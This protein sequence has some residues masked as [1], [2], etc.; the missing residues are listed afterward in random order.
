MKKYLFLALT[1]ALGASVFTSCTNDA[2]V[3]LGKTID[4]AQKEYASAFKE[5]FGDCDMMAVKYVNVE[6]YIPE[7]TG[8]FTL[9][10]YDGHPA[11]AQ[12]IGKF[13]NLTPA[14]TVNVGVNCP[15]D[16][17]RLFFTLEQNGASKV[18]NCS[19]TKSNKA[20]ARFAP[21]RDESYQNYIDGTF[22]LDP[23]VNG[24]AW[25]SRDFYNGI[26]KA[27]VTIAGLTDEGVDHRTAAADA[28]FAFNEDGEVTFYPVHMNGICPNQIGY[29]IYDMDRIKEGKGAII[30]EGIFINDMSQ[31]SSEKFLMKGSTDQ[32]PETFYNPFGDNVIE[33]TT[34]NYVYSRPFTVKVPDAYNN[35]FTNLVVGLTIYN[36]WNS[37]LKKVKYYSMQSL[38][39]N[40]V[41]MAA[42]AQG[43]IDLQQNYEGGYNTFNGTYGLVGLEDKIEDSDNDLNDIIFYTEAMQVTEYQY[44][45]RAKYYIG[46]EDLG[47]TNDFDF[48]DVVLQIEYSSGEEDA[49]VSV[50]AAG[51]VLPVGVYYEKTPLWDNVHQAFGVA[52][53]VIVNTIKKSSPVA[54]L[55]YV[56]NAAPLTTS[57]KVPYDF[58]I[59]KDGLPFYLVVDGKYGQYEIRRNSND[60]TPQAVVIGT[61]WMFN[62]EANAVVTNPT[63]NTWQWPREKVSILEAYPGISTWADNPDPVAGL[64]WLKTGVASKLY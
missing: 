47:G 28:T 38:N 2:E 24:Y 49:N 23:L 7:G 54:G 15:G 22:Q 43:K 56:E 12:M 42:Y 25:F 41:Q 1:G 63:F 39:E 58:D 53:N 21:T 40:N 18:T 37:G 35:R 27:L 29:F 52:N 46:F 60:G 51:G 10:I 48:N 14:S 50:L 31:N 13:E 32:A 26:P 20:V 59:T 3:E 4:Q 55:D 8:N 33:Y 62:K 30:E 57:I 64:E 19:I 45:E 9:R 61:S 16:A 36:T 11:E 5:K 34:T 44:E 6:A 17:T